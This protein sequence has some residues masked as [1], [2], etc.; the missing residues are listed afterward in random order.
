MRVQ[1]SSITNGIP[2]YIIARDQFTWLKSTVD[3][4]S[5]LSYISEIIILDNNSSYEPLLDWY[6]S[7]NHTVMRFKE[8]FG[9][10]VLWQK[11]LVPKTHFV[12]TD[13]DLMPCDNPTDM[14]E[15]FHEV[16]HKYS[17]S[18]VGSALQ[19]DD[20]ERED[21]VKWESQFW[22]NKLEA[23]VYKA[24]LD[25]TFALYMPNAEY[26]IHNAARVAGQYTLKHLPWYEDKPHDYYYYRDNIDKNFTHWTVKDIS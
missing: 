8:N 14:I 1:M 6:G 10:R 7:T 5:N 4:I 12:L 22:S 24:N 23:D 21:V 26:S 17:L 20:V 9:E 16:L 13:P 18:K 3:W 19:L 11:N 2:A 15:T 25:T